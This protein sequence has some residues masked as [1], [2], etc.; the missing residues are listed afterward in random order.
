MIFSNL[1]VFKTAIFSIYSFFDCNANYSPFLDGCLGAGLVVKAD[2]AEA[3]AL[4]GGAV[5]EDLTNERNLLRLLTNERRVL[6]VL[7]N[8]RMRT[9]LLMTFPKG[10]NI[11]IS[12]ASPNSWGR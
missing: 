10:R 9:L 6:R 4:V 5:D 8:V 2:E 7:T 3:L 1:S 11:C 12:S